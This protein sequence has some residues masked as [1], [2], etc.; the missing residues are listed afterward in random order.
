[1]EPYAL[2][3]EIGARDFSVL[4]QDGATTARRYA[5]AAAG[6]PKLLVLAHGAGAGQRH[7][8]M[9]AIATRL[10]EAGVEVVTFNF[11]YLERKRR[12]PDRAPVLEACFRAVIA[13]CADGRADAPRLFIGGKSM[14]GRMATHLAA[15]G[16]DGL[17][18][19]VALGY[20][21]HPPG[22]PEQMRDAHLTSIKAPAL[23]C[24]GTNDA[25][26]ASEELR[27]AAKKLERA[28][29]HL[30]EGADHGFGVKKSSGRTR[31]DVWG[32][33]VSAMVAWLGKLT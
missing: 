10:A 27:S 11:P 15:Q 12:V 5:P 29:V 7:P 4:L 2:S 22:K 26:A 1:V 17:C 33:A 14:G 16:V 25:F 9:V 30:L 31:E 18:G 20:P 23:F 28:T 3:G 6:R 24:S 8:F 21:L 32:E 19:V 13:A